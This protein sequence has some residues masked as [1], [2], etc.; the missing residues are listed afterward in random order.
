M[1]AASG[2]DGA[3]Q[4]AYPGSDPN[5][6][7]VTAIDAAKRPYRK[8]NY[9]AEVEF[10][11]PGVDVLVAEGDGVAYRTGTSYASAV[12]SGMVAQTLAG[13]RGSASIDSLRNDL[14]KSTEDHGNR[15][16]DAR[17]G[18]GLARIPGC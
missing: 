1:V 6:I 15:G 5:V 2:N 16:R 4:V 17:F 7:A 13:Q 3:A 8:A 18:W 9:G 10:A 14:R 12:V 11:A